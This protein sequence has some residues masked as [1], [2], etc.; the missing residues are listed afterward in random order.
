MN[1][2]LVLFRLVAVCSLKQK[3]L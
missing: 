1:F 3:A 2:L